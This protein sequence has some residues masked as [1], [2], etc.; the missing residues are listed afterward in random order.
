MGSL[1]SLRKRS[2]ASAPWDGVDPVQEIRTQRQH[3]RFEGC[4][5]GSFDQV[6]TQF[7]IGADVNEVRPILTGESETPLLAA[8]QNKRTA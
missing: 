4:R 7:D 8:V 1:R 3:F 2:V 5:S 6:Q